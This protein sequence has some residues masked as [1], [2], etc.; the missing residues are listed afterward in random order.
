MNTKTPPLLKKSLICALTDDERRR[1]GIDLATT[2]EDMEAVEAE[3]KKNADH[4][5]D[6]IAGLQAAA[7]TLRLK[8]SSGQE[9][10]EVECTVVFGQ[11]TPD[12]KQTIRNDTGEVVAT[13]W[14]SEFDKQGML[15]LDETADDGVIDVEAEPVN[16]DIA[17]P[18]PDAEP[19]A[20]VVDEAPRLGPIAEAEA[21]GRKAFADGKPIDK[22]PY[23]KKRVKE[24]HAWAQ[25]WIAA[26]DEADDKSEQPADAEPMP[27]ND[28][29]APAP[30]SEDY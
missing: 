16:E 25:G 18:D 19:V 1:Y 22:P 13:E 2:L 5:K 7:D 6:R 15:P 9:W 10:R 26:Q 20:V 28:P 23:T 3:K 8:V 30:E 29:E 27:D 24:L 12:R 17:K 11:P 4:F 14:M 21:A